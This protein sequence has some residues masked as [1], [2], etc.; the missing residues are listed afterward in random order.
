MKTIIQ[1]PGMITSRLMAGLEVGDL[2]VSIG[3]SHLPGDGGRTRYHYAIDRKEGGE[4]EEHDLQSG[5]QGGDLNFGMESL[6]SF[7]DAA[8]ERARYWDPDEQSG[9]EGRL[10]NEEVD[11][12]CL[13][14]QSEIEEAALLFEDGEPK[15]FIEE[16]D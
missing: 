6:L 7:M 4:Y 14:N 10:F 11:G 5:R 8:A 12:W 3:Y 1:P 15:I 2:T 13:E 9:G 16:D